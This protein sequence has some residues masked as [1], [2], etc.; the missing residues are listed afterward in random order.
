MSKDLVCRSVPTLVSDCC[1]YSKFILQIIA[2]KH[3][4]IFLV[5]KWSQSYLLLFGLQ[6]L[7]R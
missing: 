7:P 5:S 3:R 2:Y 1:N 4:D 6:I